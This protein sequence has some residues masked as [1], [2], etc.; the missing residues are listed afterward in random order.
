MA[1]AGG[2]LLM[3]GGV[4]FGAISFAYAAFSA[5]D[6]RAAAAWLGV[7]GVLAGAASAAVGL[8]AIFPARGDRARSVWGSV[9]LALG[10]VVAGGGLLLGFVAWVS[11][12]NQRPDWREGLLSVAIGTAIA[13]VGARMRDRSGS[14]PT[15]VP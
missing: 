9:V 1:W 13:I 12:G 3:L 10:L 15:M 14:G 7:L 5:A 8:A 11:A 4:A 6:E 2:W